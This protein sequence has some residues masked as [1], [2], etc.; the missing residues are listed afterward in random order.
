MSEHGEH[1]LDITTKIANVLQKKFQW[2][3]MG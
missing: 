3:L 1:G 2:L